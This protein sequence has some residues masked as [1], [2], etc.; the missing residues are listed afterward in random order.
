MRI[1]FVTWSIGRDGG[2]RAIFEIANKLCERGHD[3]KI[4]TLGGDH[5]W[6]DL[7]A[8]IRYL[9]VP[10][11]LKT[12]LFIYRVL[13]L[14]HRPYSASALEGFAKKFGFHADLIKMLTENIPEADVHIATWYPTSLALWFAR[15]ESKKFYFLQDYPEVVYE[16]NGKYGLGM[17]DVTLLLPF[18]TF[19]CNSSYTQNLVLKRQPNAKTIITGVGV[20]TRVFRPYNSKLI[21]LKGKNVAMMFMRGR[22]FKGDEISVKALNVV[23]QKIP[24]HVLIVGQKTAVKRLFSLIRPQFTYE[25]FEDIDD[26]LLAKLYSSAD[27]FL[28]TSYAES[29]SLPPLEAMACGTPVVT[30]DCKGNRDYAISEANSLVVPPGNVKETVEAVIR[31]L[32]SIELREKLAREGLKT[33]KQWNWDKVVD[34]FE[35]AIR[36][37]P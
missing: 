21:N 8:S 3:V 13:T 25:V 30:T 24:L 19:L 12:V 28:L 5:S 33:A 31:V 10:R 1:C 14:R 15:T 4:I 17:F 23:A 27:V 16:I 18:D 37:M 2:S 32:T 11:P 22:S 36:E 35:Q 20:N 29:F 26:H 6:Y 34:R 7:K 9:P